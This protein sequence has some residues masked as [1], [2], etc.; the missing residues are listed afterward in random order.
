MII[1][2]HFRSDIFVQLQ[3]VRNL[4]I[5]VKFQHYVLNAQF[6]FVLNITDLCFPKSSPFYP[7]VCRTFSVGII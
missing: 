2:N 3:N 4:P 6:V 5:G 7:A 1:I